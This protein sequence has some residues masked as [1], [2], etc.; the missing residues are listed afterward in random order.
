MRKHAADTTSIELE[1]VHDKK[2]VGSA[3]D[4]VA[5]TLDTM[6]VNHAD[7]LHMERLGKKQE[8]DVC[9]NAVLCLS[10]VARVG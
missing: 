3:P 9:A 5:T 1:P 7:R 4:W 10:L 2:H 6:E 8:F